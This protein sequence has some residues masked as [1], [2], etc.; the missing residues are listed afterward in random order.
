MPDW[1]VG[2]F[3]A[4]SKSNDGQVVIRRVTNC[5]ASNVDCYVVYEILTASA[6]FGGIAF[7]YTHADMCMFFLC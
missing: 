1:T 2:L 5:N 6:E 3:F 7:H 4:R